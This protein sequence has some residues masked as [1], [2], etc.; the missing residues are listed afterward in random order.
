MRN[1]SGLFVGDVWEIWG[2]IRE[3]RQ[4]EK[5]GRNSL[6]TL[7]EARD[8]AA[9]SSGLKVLMP[10]GSR[11]PR[12]LHRRDREIWQQVYLFTFQWSLALL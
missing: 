10:E 5:A 3:S 4:P 7:P 2:R 11:Q 6:A 9:G 1:H 12:A 8:V